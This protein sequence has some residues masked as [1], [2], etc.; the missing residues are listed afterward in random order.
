[1]EFKNTIEIQGF[2][3][4]A[5]GTPVGDDEV[6]RFSVATEY[7][8]QDTA[9]LPV[10]ETTWVQC[11]GW[12]S[13]HPDVAKIVRRTAVNVKGRLVMRR[14]VASDGGDRLSPEILV[15]K[16]TIIDDTA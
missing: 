11:V 13:K 10:V 15:S 12:K 9:G 6:V 4:N 3:G 16:V 5:H 8:F 14:Y 2:V 1:M 7:V